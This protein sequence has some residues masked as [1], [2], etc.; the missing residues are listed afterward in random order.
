MHAGRQWKICITSPL[1]IED[2][3]RNKAEEEVR[4]MAA[5]VYATSQQ[6]SLLVSQAGMLA[7]INNHGMPAVVSYLWH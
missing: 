5:S 1:A 2:C 6:G 7:L 4:K 3:D